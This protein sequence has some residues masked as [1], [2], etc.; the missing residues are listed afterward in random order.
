MMLHAETR[1]ADAL[2]EMTVEQLLHLGARQMVYL[3]TGMPD[4]ELAFMIYSADGT[5]L[6]VV[7]T[8]EDAQMAAAENDVTIAAVH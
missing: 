4:G 3:K 1:G 6:E 7:D 8:I 2:R 5:C